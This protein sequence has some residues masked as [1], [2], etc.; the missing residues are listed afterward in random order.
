MW[1]R[2]GMVAWGALGFGGA[3]AGNKTLDELYDRGKKSFQTPPVTDSDKDAMIKQYQ[4]DLQLQKD[5]VTNWMEIN[6]D[7]DKM[8]FEQNQELAKMKQKTQQA[9]K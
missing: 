7:K 2:V 4:K 8:I 9:F 6:K 1:G 3:W 5:L